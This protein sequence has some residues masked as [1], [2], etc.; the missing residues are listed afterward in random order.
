MPRCESNSICKSALLFDS[1]S[2]FQIIEVH[3]TV[4]FVFGNKYDDC[5][6]IN[7]KDFSILL[8]KPSVDY[9]NHYCSFSKQALDLCVLI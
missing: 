1:R 2:D 3:F 8:F 5:N 9:D 6:H 4:Q 7:Q